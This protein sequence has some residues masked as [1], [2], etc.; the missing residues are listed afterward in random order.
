M[1]K[2]LTLLFI[3]IF[4]SAIYIYLT[5]GKEKTFVRLPFYG[6]KQ[7]IHINKNGKPVTDTAF[8]TV[9]G[10]SFYNQAGNLFNS[11]LL[12]GRIWVA[13][14]VDIHD[15]QKAPAMAVLMNRI[16][17]RTNLDTTIRLITFT[18]DSES[19]K[20][21]QGYATM[22]H[23]TAGKKRMFL[24]GNAQVLNHLA[25][26]GFYQPV[27]YPSD[28]FNYFFLIDKEGHIRGIYNGFRVKEIDRLIDEINMLKA[29][30]FIQN[31]AKKEKEGKADK[32][33]AM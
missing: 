9:P 20:S 15:N 16:E 5:A 21:M 6:P 22:I 3:L 31:E 25:T 4:P 17:E 7:P 14:F 24:S 10:F 23:A 19:T 8:Y 1:K 29:A 27:K 2:T 28:G 26:N 11:G 12:N 33:G 18:L 13:Y 32:D 30:Y